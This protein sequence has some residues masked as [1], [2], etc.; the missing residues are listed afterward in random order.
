MGEQEEVGASCAVGCSYAAMLM[1]FLVM[2]WSTLG[3]F[4]EDSASN[5]GSGPAYFWYIYVAIWVTM[6]CCTGGTLGE[7]YA[8]KE[9]Q[10]GS[11]SRQGERSVAFGLCAY[12]FYTMLW[13]SICLSCTGGRAMSTVTR[14]WTRVT[15]RASAPV[16]TEVVM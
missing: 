13:T 11:G 7:A 15:R 10:T 8:R 16:S 14:V 6:C 1:M 9:E 3:I 2:I 12:C 5:C 4:S